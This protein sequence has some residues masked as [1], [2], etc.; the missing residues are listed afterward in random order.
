MQKMELSSGLQSARDVGVSQNA[1]LERVNS[2]SK[3]K[4]YQLGHRLSVKWSIG[5]GPRIGCVKDYPMELKM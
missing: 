2:K 1:I 4:F 5:N 3:T